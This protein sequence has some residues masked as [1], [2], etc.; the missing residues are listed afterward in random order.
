MP[1]FKKR[2]S[3]TINNA[4]PEEFEKFL[5]DFNRKNFESFGV[6]AISIKQPDGC[7]CNSMFKVNPS[8][9]SYDEW[10]KILSEKYN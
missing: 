2:I 9:H 8:E 1:K 10:H 7:I 6:V 4:T 3:M 5:E